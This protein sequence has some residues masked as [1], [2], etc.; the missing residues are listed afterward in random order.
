M[1]LEYR[2]ASLESEL[3]RCKSEIEAVKDRCRSEIQTLTDRESERRRK[4]SDYWLA[5]TFGILCG[6][7]SALYW[8]L[9]LTRSN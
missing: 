5:L 6:A 4:R 8:G 2:V 9:I 1:S 7:I 3:Q